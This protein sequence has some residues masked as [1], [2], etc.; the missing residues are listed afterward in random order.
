MAVTGM[1]GPTPEGSKSEGTVSQLNSDRLPGVSQFTGATD[2]YSPGRGDDI[3][4]FKQ[5]D[6]SKKSPIKIID[7]ED[8][9]SDQFSDS[10]DSEDYGRGH[11]EHWIRKEEE[12]LVSPR[13]EEKPSP[14]KSV[15]MLF[16][17][18]DGDLERID[19]VISS[20]KSQVSSSIYD[21]YG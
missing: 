6:S 14:R 16:D 4:E 17:L 5:E 11:L 8:N 2:L 19:S 7:L 15:K 20:P 9:Q 13:H 3:S 21:D 12:M 1:L 18:D 10:E